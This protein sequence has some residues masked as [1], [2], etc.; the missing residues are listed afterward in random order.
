L[1]KTKLLTFTQSAQDLE[2]RN[3]IKLNV[4]ETVTT[5]LVLLD[6]SPWSCRPSPLPVPLD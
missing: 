2:N 3:T 6:V 1:R 4:N 5:R